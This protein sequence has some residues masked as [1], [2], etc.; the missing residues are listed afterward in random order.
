MKFYYKK[1][2]DEYFSL[3]PMVLRKK[4]NIVPVY[5]LV[6]T[7][8]R[9]SVFKSTVGKSLGIDL[10]S[11]EQ[12]YLRVGNGEKITVYLHEVEVRIA[13]KVI[14]KARIGFSD[15]LGT[16]FNLLGRES[17]FNEFKIC[18]SDKEKVIEFNPE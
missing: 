16:S 3:V 17:I 15:E 18:F 4:M 10:F 13:G 12:R 5:P 8:A 6:D 11:G 2:E 1:I 14:K 7:G 9:Y